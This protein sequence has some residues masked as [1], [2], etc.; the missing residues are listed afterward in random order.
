MQALLK[1]KKIAEI[2]YSGYYYR[3]NEEGITSN[4]Q[5][6]TTNIQI[7]KILEQMYEVWKQNEKENEEKKPYI[8]LYFFI[9]IGFG[10]LKILCNNLSYKQFTKEYNR[11]IN[12]FKKHQI[13]YHKNPLLKGKEIFKADK[14]RL[15]MKIFMILDQCKLGKIA[16][17]LQ[18]KL[19]I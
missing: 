9:Y 11:V 10:Y 2:D 17:F 3:K 16:L 18:Y 8:E 4:I 7:D 12:F 14:T 19:P 13:K 5:K 1:T 6:N 15:P